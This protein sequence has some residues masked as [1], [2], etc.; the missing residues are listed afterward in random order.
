MSK[1]LYKIVNNEYAFNKIIVKCGNL[2]NNTYNKK[3]SKSIFSVE[4]NSIYK[5]EYSE[6]DLSVNLKHINEKYNFKNNHSSIVLNIKNENVNFYID[7]YLDVFSR[8]FVL[9]DKIKND[10]LVFIPTKFV[11]QNLHRVSKYS[12]ETKK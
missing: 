2:S 11:N 6:T 4:E 3:I 9:D 1:T 5:C 7:L 12:L 8:N 10:S